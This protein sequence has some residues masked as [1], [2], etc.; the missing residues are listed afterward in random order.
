MENKTKNPKAVEIANQ[1]GL[2]YEQAVKYIKRH[3]PEW[4]V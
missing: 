2:T 3:H 4:D 1:H